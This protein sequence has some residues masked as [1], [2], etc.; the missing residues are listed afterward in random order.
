MCNQAPTQ[1]FKDLQEGLK[2]AGLESS[3]LIVGVDFTK[4]NLYNGATTFNGKSLHFLSD[5]VHNPYEIVLQNICT[6]LSA[7]DDDNQ[8]PCYGFGDVTSRNTKVFSFQDN[9][10][11]CNGLETVRVSTHDLSWRRSCIILLR[12][13]LY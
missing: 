10:E 3:E 13:A 11:P 12:S 8:I 9:E 5:E 6:T 4:S 7:F 2:S 1:T